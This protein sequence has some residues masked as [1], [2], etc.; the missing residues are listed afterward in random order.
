MFKKKHQENTK[1]FFTI[2]VFFFEDTTVDFFQVTLH[3]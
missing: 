1:P 2:F 3:F